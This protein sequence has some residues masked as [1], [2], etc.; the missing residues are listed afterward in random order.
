MLKIGVITDTNDPENLRRVLVS[1]TDR[2]ISVSNWVQRIT[3]FDGDDLPLPEIGSTVVI[4]E[5]DGDATDE[6]VLGVLQTSLTNKP[7]GKTTLMDWV[8]NLYRMLF[9][10][11]HSISLKVDSGEKAQIVANDVGDVLLSNQR[12]SILLKAD[13]YT[14]ITNPQGTIS[15]GPGGIS[16]N[17]P[18][19]VNINSTGLLY[20]GNQVAVVGGVDS[21]GDT[22]LS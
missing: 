20:N 14:S 12:G 13:G 18:Y 11:Q 19:P 7:N 3:L 9:T 4:G 1:S 21:D 16:I 6:V 8:A 5:I 2:G 22:T 15:M 10:A 17:T